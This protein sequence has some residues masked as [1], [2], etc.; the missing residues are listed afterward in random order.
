MLKPIVLVLSIFLGSANMWSQEQLL[1]KKV[2]FPEL[3]EKLQMADDTLRV[4]NF[5]ATW[6]KPCIAELP[7]FESIAGDLN[8]QAFQLY[9]VSLDFPELA[10]TKLQNFIIKNNI[11]SE[12]WL[13]NESNPSE[14][15]DLIEPL[16]SGAIPMTIVMHKGK[17]SFAEN[18]FESKEQLHDFFIQC[19]NTQP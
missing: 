15:I 16:W 1:Y 14:W 10:E 12:V 13:F 4:F 11:K 9:L 7:Y 18:T 5:W 17:R 8:N 2:Y 3:L 19:K 6:C